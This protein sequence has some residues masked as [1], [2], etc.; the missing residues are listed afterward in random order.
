MRYFLK[1]DIILS[2]KTPKG[3]SGM[4]CGGNGRRFGLG[5][6]FG[7]SIPSTDAA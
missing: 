6:Y 4:I 7:L 5:P 3:M 2:K 1:L